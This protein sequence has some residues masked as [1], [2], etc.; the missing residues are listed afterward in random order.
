MVRYPISISLAVTNRSRTTV[1]TSMNSGLPS[2]IHTNSESPS[3]YSSSART[4]NADYLDGYSVFSIEDDGVTLRRSSGPSRSHSLECL[5]PF[6]NCSRTFDDASDWKT[7]ILSH[8]RTHMP[9]S[10]TGCPFCDTESF[11][12]RN[13]WAAWEA[14]L[15]HIKRH[16]EIEGVSM[17]TARPDFGLF[18]W[19]WQ[20]KL[21]GDAT[22][23]ALFMSRPDQATVNIQRMPGGGLARRERVAQPYTVIANSAR[24]RRRR[25]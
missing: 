4:S 12:S 19:L 2:L 5:F 7:H 8:F 15:D 21:I 10:P 22:F 25:R 20:E 6:L 13:G 17:A 14:K 3:D 24:E 18:T 23:K 11:N 16:Y 9:P 1:D